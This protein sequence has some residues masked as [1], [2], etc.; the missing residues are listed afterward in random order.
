M[1]MMLMILSRP[2]HSRS[3]SFQY[4]HLLMV[5]DMMKKIVNKLMMTKMRMSPF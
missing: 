1:A 4:F 5:T 2:L 3:H